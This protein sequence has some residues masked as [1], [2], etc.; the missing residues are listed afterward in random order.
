MIAFLVKIQ[1]EK[2]KIQKKL[3]IA[4]DE[5][6]KIVTQT[7]NMIKTIKL[8]SW[9]DAFTNKILSKRE[10]E[11]DYLKQINSKNVYTNALYWSGNLILSLLSI[12][13]YSLL[14]N[15]MNTANILTS[16]YIFNSTFS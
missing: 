9:E 6:M 4:R 2:L 1:G 13:F 14:G 8:Y 3:N 10:N 11:L 7:F 5:R 15:E 16:I 12:G